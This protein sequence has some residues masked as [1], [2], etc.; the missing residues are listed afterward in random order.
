MDRKL[1]ENPNAWM[2]W[3]AVLGYIGFMVFIAYQVFTRSTPKK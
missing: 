3:T 2:D 1:V